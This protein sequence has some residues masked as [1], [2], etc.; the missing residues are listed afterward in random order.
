M[1]GKT[2][3]LKAYVDEARPINGDIRCIYLE[4][5]RSGGVGPEGIP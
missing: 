3:D 4:E 2:K 1:K 5:I